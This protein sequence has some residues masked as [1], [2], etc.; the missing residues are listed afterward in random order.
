M[1]R[2]WFDIER[3]LSRLED[4]DTATLEE[5][6]R[7]MPPPSQNPA[8]HR[9]F[10]AA[11]QR[12]RRCLDVRAAVSSKDGLVNHDGDHWYKKPVGIVVLAVVGGLLLALIKYYCG[13]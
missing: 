1:P 4:L 2:D 8:F 6:S 9:K 12:I 11:M 3:E 13:L 10:D 7:V 5:F